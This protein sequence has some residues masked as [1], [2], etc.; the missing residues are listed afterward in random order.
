MFAIIAI[1]IIS[2]ALALGAGGGGGGA[3]AGGGASSASG[4]GSSGGSAP[5][6]NSSWIVTVGEA[7]I[8][9]TAEYGAQ[10]GLEKIHAAEAYAALAKNGKNIA[11]D[12]IKIAITDSGAQENHLDI[13]GN[14]SAVDNYNYH[15]NSNDVSD[16]VGS[17][18]YAASLAAGVKNDIGIQGVAYNANLVIADIAGTSFVASSGIS[19]S[20]AIDG[21]KVI[22]AGWKYGTY[23]SY[24]G[25]PSGTN[26]SD[27]DVIA[28]IKIAQSR[29]VLLVAA[30]GNDADNDNNGGADPAY[31][32]RPKP[33]RP[34]LLANN[35]ELSGYVLAVGAVDQNGKI[36][37]IS[38][39]CGITHDYC[40]VA[41]GVDIKGAASDTNSIGGIGN[42][43]EKY[44]TISST[45]A[46]ASQVSGAAAVLRAAWP[47][48]TAPQVAN[49]L[50][51]TAT[52]LGAVGNDTTYGAGLIN[53]YAAVQAQGSNSFAY[54]TSV[55][56]ISYDV[57]SSSII[58]DPIFG[59]AFTHNV[60][61]ALQNAVF[62]DDYGRDYK[63]FLE[64]RIIA[65]GRSSAI[66]SLGNNITAGNYKTNILPLSFTEKNSTNFSQIKLQ[67]KSY[68]DIG[69]KF[70]IID[71]STQDKVLDNGSGFSFTQ[72]FSQKTQFGFAFNVDEVRNLTSEKLNNFGFISTNGF[73]AN[74][75]QS[76]I[77]SNSQSGA[78]TKNFNQIFLQHQFL[79]DKLKLNFSHQTSYESNAIL[80]SAHK[81]QNQISDFGFNY[82]P[83]KKTNLTFSL[84]N[85]REFNNNFLNS[86]TIG[87]FESGSNS[88]TS[89]FKIAVSQKLYNNLSLV[90]N[91]SEGVTKISGNNLGVFRD[92]QNIRS[93]AA[94]IG[95]VNDN[96]FNGRLGML[97]SE[98][99]RVYSGKAI[100]DIPIARDNAGNVT[101]YR[102]NVSLKPQGKERNFEIFYAKNLNISAQISLNFLT[103][104]DAGNFKGNRSEYL[105]AINYSA[106]F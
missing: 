43:G 51:A 22:N 92:Y 37:D 72:D 19:G 104:K 95:L 36:A 82:S 9:R 55:S 58:S 4:G 97:Y 57:R 80:T 98:P 33:A 54:G 53:L 77:S 66:N 28:A 32:S 7:N 20:A 60:A 47:A 50:L 30:T 29:D 91:F 48:L 16:A 15:Q 62:F 44:A 96:I 75:Y 56:Q 3:G 45:Y 38:N 99:L 86:Q 69:K 17:G 93:R 1:I 27:R 5:T 61:P 24:N 64:N 79:Q 23:T 14:L 94:A 87:A 11:G 103:T 35:N 84:G 88:K 73:A 68:S 74:P 71:K 100:I 42:V 25:T 105:S 41:P 76:F 78:I 101:R 67:I 106:K 102:A 83:N 59:D 63:A 12:S 89:Y 26:A 10:W 70:S 18:T 52:D 65:R 81:L 46:A 21:V 6:I 13:A 8:Y 39:I 40:L 85:L 31:L 2:S 34:A 49:I 90:T